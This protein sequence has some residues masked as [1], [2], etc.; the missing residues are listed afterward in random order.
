MSDKLIS[1]AGTFF[2]LFIFFFSA[3]FSGGFSEGNYRFSI[4]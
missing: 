2:L 3:G 4:R 1:W